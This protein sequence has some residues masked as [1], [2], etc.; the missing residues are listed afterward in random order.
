MSEDSSG[1]YRARRPPRQRLL[2]GR[3]GRIGVTYWGPESPQPIVMLHG[4]MDCGAAY[5]LLA[6]ALPDDWPLMAIDWPGYGH[7]DPYPGGYW[8]PEYLA[9]LEWLLDR[10]MPDSP[11]RMIGH[12]L[13]GTVASLLAGLRPERLRWLVNLEGMGLPRLDP[14]AS[15]DHLISW[16][17]ALRN[18]P[19]LRRYASLDELATTVQSRNPHLS[20]AR[21]R[22]LAGVWSSPMENGV[23]LLA[24]PLHQLPNPIRYT[25]DELNACME[26]I[27]CPVLL[28]I[29]AESHYLQR[30]GGTELLQRWQQTLRSL[31]VATVSD[32]AHMLH[33]EQ[34]AQCARH[35]VDFVAA[36]S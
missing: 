9:D 3:R 1:D 34:S 28:L 19:R 29:G 11:V 4:W 5:Q 13:G 22:F 18:P 32:A 26:R 33:Y 7:S 12:S 14:G 36:Q 16:L 21:A 10:V 15:L 20:P 30:V 17:D 8:L 6:D 23:Q 35:I 25:R 27:T 24:D 2:D 31:R